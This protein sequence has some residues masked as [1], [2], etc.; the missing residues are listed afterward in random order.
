VEEGMCV[1][2]SRVNLKMGGADVTDTFLRMMLYDHFPYDEINVKRRYDLLLADEIKQKHLTMNETDISVQLYDFHVRAPGQDTRKYQFKTYDEVILAVEGLFQ[3]DI[4][5]HRGKLDARHKLI[6]ASTDL[7]DGSPNDPTSNAQSE[8]INLH[9]PSQPAGAA[10]GEIN[11]TPAAATPAR[12]APSQI[13]RLQ[14]NETTSNRNSPAPEGDRDTPGPGGEEKVDATS[15]LPAC[16]RDDV[17]PIHPLPAAILASITH[18][19]KGD[20]RRMRDFLLGIMVI[21]GGAQV[22][23]FL[24]ILEDRL[25]ILNPRFAKDITVGP[26]PRELDPQGVIWKG[27]SVCGKLRS[28]ND[29]WIGKLEYDRLGARC[30]AYKCMW[31]W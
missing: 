15:E 10:N 19:A 28:T 31:A 7:Y 5:D 2:N 26:P 23:G 24:T 13:S 3:P 1:E 27:G 14:D 29:L 30:L 21:G 8:I 22:Q 17:L 9:A 12:P 11:G 25:K 16:L 4:F 18:G 6:G 20:E